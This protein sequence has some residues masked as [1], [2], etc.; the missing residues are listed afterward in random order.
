VVGHH[1]SLGGNS[2]GGAP[3]SSTGFPRSRE[4]VANQIALQLVE[5]PSALDAAVQASDS[6]AVVAASH[7]ELIDRDAPDALRE[8][9]ES[10]EGARTIADHAKYVGLRLLT[11]ANFGRIVAQAREIAVESLD[12]MR[13]RVPK[14]IGRVAEGAVLG[15]EVLLS[16]IGPDTTACR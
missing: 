5:E 14:A 10:V 6:L 8:P 13:K 11:A 1:A 2:L 12:E 7:P 9:K 4:I 15:G 16:V 3:S